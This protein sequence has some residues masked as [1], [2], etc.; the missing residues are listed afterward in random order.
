MPGSLG[1]GEFAEGAGLRGLLEFGVT[2]VVWWLDIGESFTDVSAFDETSGVVG[3]AG[4]RGGFGFPELTSGL[5][6]AKSESDR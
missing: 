3:V 6:N 4:V 5:V 1:G 2:G